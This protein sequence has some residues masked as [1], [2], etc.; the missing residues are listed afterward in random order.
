MK[1]HTRATYCPVADI[2]NHLL[3]IPSSRIPESARANIKNYIKEINRRLIAFD[4]LQISKTPIMLVAGTLEK[5][6]AIHHLLT[7]R[8]SFTV[9]GLC[10]DAATADAILKLHGV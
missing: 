10:T 8:N 2:A 5:A 7:S 1:R 6:D 9:K 4:D 3:Y